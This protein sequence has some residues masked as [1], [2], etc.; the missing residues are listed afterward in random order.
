MLPS[1]FVWNPCGIPPSIPPLPDH[2]LRSRA[3]FMNPGPR[4]TIS[5]S[6]SI[7]PK[8]GRRFTAT[9]GKRWRRRRWTRRSCVRSGRRRRQRPGW[10]RSSRWRLGGRTWEVGEEVCPGIGPCAFRRGMQAE[11][12]AVLVFLPR[13]RPKDGRWFNPGNRSVIG[14]KDASR[15]RAYGCLLSSF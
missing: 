13:S 9:S 7:L 4:T 2:R 11:D 3:F 12:V 15:N 1:L 8:Q 10:S 5:D 14:R 6:T